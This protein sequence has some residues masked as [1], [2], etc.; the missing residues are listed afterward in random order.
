M[1]PGRSERDREASGG[2]GSPLLT[3]LFFGVALAG[4]ALD[5]LTPRIAIYVLLSLTFVRLLPVRL[6]VLGSRLNPRSVLYIGWFG[7]RGLA[8]I[9]FALFVVE[10]AN[11]PVADDLL[12]VVTWT[13]LA[14][15]VLHGVSS[16]W[17]ANAYGDWYER[18]QHAHEMPEDV[19]VEEMRTR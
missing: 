12:L 6:A 16:V 11:L 1:P 13:V 3:F 8:S 14:S 17:S 5:Q 4:P 9:L 7:P 19:E 15:I 2:R 18:Y 10:D